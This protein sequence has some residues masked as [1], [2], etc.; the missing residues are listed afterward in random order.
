MTRASDLA[1]LDLLDPGLD[2]SW[3][4][5]LATECSEPHLHE[6]HEFLLAERA[7][8]HEVLPPDDQVFAAFQRTPLHAVKAVIVGQDPYHGPGQ[9]MGLS[10]SVRRGVP[11]PPSLRNIFAELEADVGVPRPTHGD[12]RAWADRGVLLLNTALTVRSGDAGSH[13]GRGWEQ[14]TDAAIR[15]LAARPAGVAFMLWGRHAQAKASMIDDARHLVIASA[16][17]SPLSA[18]T[19]FFGSRP[20]SRV[21]AWL[22]SRGVAPIDWSLPD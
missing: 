20:F 5:A 2:P 22:E 1:V 6:L 17:P 9:A 13:S 18:R 14:L 16:H 11:V 15:V 8:G 3:S 12:L 10:F 21:N 4:E 7:A 19:G